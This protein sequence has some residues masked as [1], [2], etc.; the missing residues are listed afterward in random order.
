L[1]SFQI[2]QTWEKSFEFYPW[3]VFSLLSKKR[4]PAIQTE[5]REKRKEGYKKMRKEKERDG[6]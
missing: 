3:V 2:L 1:F 5:S 4:L 6:D